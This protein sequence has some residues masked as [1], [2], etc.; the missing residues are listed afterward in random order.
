MMPLQGFSFETITYLLG[1]GFSIE[2]IETFVE[3]AQ[4]MMVKSLDEHPG[5]LE[6]E[7]KKL[8]LLF[9]E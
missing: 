8:Q 2:T 7:W 5:M 9:I 6:V 4:R 3:I 1:Q